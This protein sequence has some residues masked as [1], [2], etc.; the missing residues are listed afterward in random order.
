MPG[1]SHGRS[2]C[3][4]PHATSRTSSPDAAR[5]GA[6]AGDGLARGRAVT[7]C[8]T[9]SPQASCWVAEDML[10]AGPERAL[11]GG[12]SLHCH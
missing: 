4:T 6:G 3:C 7:L 9:C 12:G 2:P 5:S 1:G 10:L 11:C 8:A